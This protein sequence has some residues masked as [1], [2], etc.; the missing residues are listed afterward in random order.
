MPLLAGK[1]N[2]GNNIAEMQNAGHPHDQAVAASLNKADETSTNL[3]KNN[4]SN[5]KAHKRHM[6]YR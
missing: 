2:I 6:E 5:N 4:N 1:K 3:P